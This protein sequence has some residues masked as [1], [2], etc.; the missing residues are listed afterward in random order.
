MEK[1]IIFDA[2]LC[3]G[4]KT[5]EKICSFVHE[6][7]FCKAKARVRDIKWENDG[8]YV[9]LSC[10]H[11]ENPFCLAVCP[12]GAI[13]KDENGSVQIDSNVCVGCRMCL[14]ACPFG[15]IDFNPATRKINKC[16]FCK[17]K[18]YEPQCALMCPTEALKV[19]PLDDRAGTYKRTKA[20]A[21]IKQQ[22]DLAMDKIKT[23]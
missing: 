12:V 2:Q 21:T 8:V 16:D 10:F 11:C 4:C 13:Y 18:G 19:V 1:I 7:V 17:D 9:P 22:V 6:G 20:M 5:C 15:M 3:A 23:T 14:Q